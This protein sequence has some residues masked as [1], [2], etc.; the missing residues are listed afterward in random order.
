MTAGAVGTYIPTLTKTLI[1]DFEI[2]VPP[3]ETQQRI[4]QVA[5][6]AEREQ[7]LLEA[8]SQK[9]TH[10]TDQLLLRLCRTSANPRKKKR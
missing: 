7:A 3:I 9:R 2:E 1:E 10:A 6:L 5:L 8:I 4:T